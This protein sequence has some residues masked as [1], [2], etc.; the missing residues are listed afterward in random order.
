MRR[1]VTPQGQK[2]SGNRNSSTGQ[3]V[4]TTSERHSDQD[5]PQR[6]YDVN[7]CPRGSPQWKAC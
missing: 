2:D 1:P 5:C 7:G 3:K 6:G 4:G